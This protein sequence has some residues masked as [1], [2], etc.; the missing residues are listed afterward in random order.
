MTNTPDTPT[1]IETALGGLLQDIGKFMQRAHGSLRHMAPAARARE[2]VVLPSDGH[3]GYSHKH[4][5]WTE[6]FFEWMEAQGLSFPQGVNLHRVRDMAVFHHKP[7]TFGALGW[8]AAEADRLSSGMD[9]KRKDEDLESEGESRGW[10]KF[11]KTAM[12]SPFCQ[13]DLGLGKPPRRLQALADLVPDERVLP[14]ANVDTSA[15]PETYARLWQGFTEEFSVLC[16]EIDS[17]DLF[18][19]GLLSLSER[20]TWAIPS[21][22][23]D[24]PDISLHDHNRTVAAIAAC[25]HA[26]HTEQETLND[27]QAIKDRSTN[28]F[29]LLAGDLSGIQSTLFILA[30]QQVKGVNKILRARSLLMGMLLDAVALHCRQTLG[31]PVFNLLQNAGGR[32]VILVP[33]LQGLNKTL[34]TVRSEIDAWLGQRYLGELALNLALSTPFSGADLMPP[35]F[36]RVQQSLSRMLEEAKQQPLRSFSTGVL[37]MNYELGECQACGKRPARHLDGNRDR[38]QVCH[39]EHRVGGWLPKVTAVSWQYGKPR[40]SAWST[41]FFNDLYLVLHEQPPQYAAGLL[42]G[43]RLYRGM[44]N[45]LPGSWPLRF[46]ANYVPRLAE[47]E[48]YKP[49][50]DDLSEDAL[51]VQP[52]EIKTFEHLAKDA[53]EPDKDGEPLGK[54][55]LAVLKADVDRLG[56]LFSFGFRDPDTHKD[57]AT[58]SRYAALSRML[59]LFFTGYLQDRLRVHFPHTYTVYAG[60]DDL[61]LIGPWRQMVELTH[62]LNVQFRRYTGDNPNITLSAGLEL[63]RANHPLNRSVW[64]AEDRLKR[65]KHR[66]DQ[67][68]GRNRVCLIDQQP[69]PWDELPQRLADAKTLNDWLRDNDKLVST[70]IIYKLLYFAEQRRRA[71][72]EFDLE[73]ANWRARW[74]YHL[75]RNIRGSK[76]IPDHRKPEVIATLNRLM[77]LDEHIR[78]QDRWIS[79]RIP[80]SIALYRNRT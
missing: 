5:L 54:P 34:E 16:R 13:V 77:G 39:E 17:L 35:H 37:A 27:G 12:L 79:P 20:Y 11:I 41:E 49:V 70:A 61:L 66:D 46:I 56:M 63:M 4:A 42:S 24:L 26:W 18:C 52:G 31:L 45:T 44:N 6:A 62:D 23:V 38:C 50:Y 53:L 58:I 22:T 2:S 76:Q 69:I 3:G 7:D 15:Y 40:G 36:H 47:G 8:L 30:N 59:D 25:L 64:A 32:F 21:S 51:E 29:R 72:Q 74:G 14:Q 57:R 71:E 1:L 33:N 9:R 28:K 65:A 75:A 19:E 43:F 73:C 68:P 10:D 48:Q 55:F 80:V 60:G 78:V 67:H